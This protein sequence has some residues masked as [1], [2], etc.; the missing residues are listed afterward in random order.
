MYQLD[1]FDASIFSPSLGLSAMGIS[2]PKPLACGRLGSMPEVTR[3]FRLLTHIRRI[4]F[5]Q[6][7]YW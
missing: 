2:L 7:A 1:E 3:A 5:N 4:K 6:P